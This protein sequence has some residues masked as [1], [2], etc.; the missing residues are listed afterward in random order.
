M[1][2]D[3]MGCQTEIAKTIRE[4]GGHYLLAVKD[5]QPTLHQDIQTTFAEADDVRRRTVDEQPRPVVEVFEQVLLRTP[6]VDDPCRT[7]LGWPADE[8]LGFG[9]GFEGAAVEVAEL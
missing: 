7:S 3:A 9:V 8:D 5:N 1:T 4:G 2:I 6:A